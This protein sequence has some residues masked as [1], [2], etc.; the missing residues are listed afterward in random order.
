MPTVYFNGVIDNSWA[1]VGNWWSDV[2]LSVPL[3]RL[4]LTTEDVVLR[5]TVTT[6]E[7]DRTVNSLA[8]DGSGAG[9]TA[10]DFSLTVTNGAT[11]SDD[12]SGTEYK[13]VI[14]G[15]CS[16]S[17][18]NTK[19]EMIIT[20]N[21][22]YAD[23]AFKDAGS[24]SGTATFNG[25]SFLNSGIVGSAVF[26][27]AT[28]SNGGDVTGDIILNNDSEFRAGNIGGNLLLNDNSVIKGTLEGLVGFVIVNYGSGSGTVT[29]NK[30]GG[31]RFKMLSVPAGGVNGSGQLG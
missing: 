14:I 7:A 18:D 24:V 16:F 10:T 6:I 25:N 4:P 3:G 27:D 5:S 12:N 19:D 31:T 13:G 29:D 28:Y 8:S 20:G 21:A 1:T 17:G 23:S 22:D 2:G 15:D 30:T 11:L 26:N 9:Y